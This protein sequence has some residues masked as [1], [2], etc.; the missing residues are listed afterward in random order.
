MLTGLYDGEILSLLSVLVELL[1][2]VSWVEPDF[3]VEGLCS[4]YG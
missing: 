1:G 3:P 4:F 2:V